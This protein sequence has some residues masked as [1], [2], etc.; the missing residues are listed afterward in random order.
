MLHHEGASRFCQSPQLPA[1]SCLLFG[2]A[3]GHKP[4]FL[5]LPK[6][7]FSHSKSCRTQH[8]QG[9]DLVVITDTG[10]NDG[11]PEALEAAGAVVHRIALRPF[12]FDTARNIALSLLPAD[13]DLCLAF[14]LDEYVQPGW[15][16]ALQ[17]SV[18]SAGAGSRCW[19]RW[20]V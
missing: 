10:S 19:C 7:Q 9:A 12:R 18:A 11:T 1:A 15:V 14:D 4:G 2:P 3:G 20:H 13:C 8:L 6:Q 5:L 17:A 16:D